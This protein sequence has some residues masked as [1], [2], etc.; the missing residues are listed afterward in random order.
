MCDRPPNV[1]PGVCDA[2]G[3]LSLGEVHVPLQGKHKM[4]EG[5]FLQLG[6]ERDLTQLAGIF[7]LLPT[8]NSLSQR[9]KVEY[10]K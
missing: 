7:R 10:R 6:A 3:D 8:L 2:P 5:Q 1:A 4:A 9:L